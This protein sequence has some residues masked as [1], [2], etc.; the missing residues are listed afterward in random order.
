MI[1]A[2]KDKRYYIQIVHYFK[3]KRTKLILSK[4]NSR[5][6]CS[7]IC[8]TNPAIIIHTVEFTKN[9]IIAG[10]RHIIYFAKYHETHNNIKLTHLA[11]ML[12]ILKSCIIFRSQKVRVIN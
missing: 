1:F 4:Y 7:I 6:M 12:E 8:C 3:E 5:L 11:P 9:L 10:K 2:I